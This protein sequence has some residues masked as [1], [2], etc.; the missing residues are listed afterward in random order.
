MSLQRLKNAAENK[1]KQKEKNEKD[2]RNENLSLKAKVD[3][4]HREGK[5]KR[6]QLREEHKNLK[7]EYDQR[8]GG[9]EF[10]LHE[11]KKKLKKKNEMIEFLRKAKDHNDNTVNMVPFQVIPPESLMPSLDQPDNQ[12]LT[13]Q[14][15]SREQIQSLF[16]SK[17]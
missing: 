7:K 3:L 11:L 15:M 13:Q 17:T 6:A 8:I 5:R 9:L 12:Q 10:E 14:D 1:L 2:L 16:N 4:L